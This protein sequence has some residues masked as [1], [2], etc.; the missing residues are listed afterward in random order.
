MILSWIWVVLI[1]GWIAGEAV[2]AIVTRTRK[3][4]GGMHDRGSQLILWVVI[5]CSFFAAGDLEGSR[6]NIPFNHLALRSLALALLVT[7]LVVR[8]VAIWT[9][10]R[11]FSA[12]V[13]IRS[14]QK[15]QRGGLYGIVRHPSYL[16]MEIIFLAAGLWTHNWV[17]LA[18]LVTL[19]TAAV[20]YRI[21]VEELA[22]IGAFGDE[23][24]QYAK[25]TRRLIPG[26]Y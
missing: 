2:I 19:P 11:A 25:S 23:Y 9:L 10:G 15:L 21:H 18:I 7:G 16:G 14:E 13:A 4:K 1:Y 17:S 20:L 22:L 6:W 24:A 12:N 8:I 3:S 26:I 5:V